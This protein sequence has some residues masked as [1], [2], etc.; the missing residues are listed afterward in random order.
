MIKT[1][2]CRNKQKKKTDLFFRFFASA[3]T[4]FGH[5]IRNFYPKTSK[6][7]V[8][9]LPF[10][11]VH[12]SAFCRVSCRRLVRRRSDRL[13]IFPVFSLVFS[14]FQPTNTSFSVIVTTRVR[15]LLKIL[16]YL[17]NSVN[18]QITTV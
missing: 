1:N 6:V 10:S 11:R 5:R 8:A 12:S 2:V 4:K 15:I 13:F 3:R 17:Y 18:I 16:F 14:V 7:T 9:L